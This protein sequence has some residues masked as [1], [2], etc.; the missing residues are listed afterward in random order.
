MGQSGRYGAG[1]RHDGASQSADDCGG[2]CVL[3]ARDYFTGAEMM[4]VIVM[5]LLSTTAVLAM[6]AMSQGY[7][8]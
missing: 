2:H 1:N 6:A 7:I 8:A 4:R 5:A 3:C